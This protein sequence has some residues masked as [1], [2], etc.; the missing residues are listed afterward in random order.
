LKVEELLKILK[1][2]DKKLD[3]KILNCHNGERY[4]LTDAY[5]RYVIKKRKEEK[6]LLLI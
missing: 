2:C 4:L 5:E 3:V 1:K 6:F